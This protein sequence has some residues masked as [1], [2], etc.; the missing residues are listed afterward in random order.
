MMVTIARS[1][2]SGKPF[3]IA[4]WLLQALG[5]VMFL[6]AGS[7]KLV[8]RHDMVALF[9]AVGTGQWFRYV[10]GALELIG[11]LLLLVPKKAALGGVLLACVMLGAVA[12][13]LTVLRMSPIEPLLILVITAV[14]AWGRWPQFSVR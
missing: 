12:V 4:L 3:N 11:A 14:I 8:G 13:H 1:A 6:G 10:T 2:V 5:A 9:D 7:G